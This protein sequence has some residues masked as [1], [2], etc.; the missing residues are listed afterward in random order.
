MGRNTAPEI[1]LYADGVEGDWNIP[2]LNN[3]AA[4]FNSRCLFHDRHGIKYSLKPQLLESFDTCDSLLSLRESYPRIIACETG[5]KSRNVFQ[6]RMKREKTA[7]I[8]GNEISGIDRTVL[9]MCDDIVHIPITGADMQSLN[10]GVAAALVFYCLLNPG[11]ERA[12]LPWKQA[13]EVLLLDPR[14]PHDLG[15][16][17][18]TLWC[19]NWDRVYLRDSHQIWYD[20]SAESRNSVLEASRGFKNHTTITPFLQCS[21]KGYET[22]FVMTEREGRPLSRVNFAGRGRTILTFCGNSD[23]CDLPEGLAHNVEP[24]HVDFPDR[25][26]GPML[27]ISASTALMLVRSIFR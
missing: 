10:V 17:L 16:I 22:A 21:G 13:P 6:Y 2:I 8:V 12:P 20:G 9:R 26:A 1:D 24:F 5:V 19:F 3:A 15:C 7:L 14:D 25:K 11:K 27:R 18:R 4:L 23:T